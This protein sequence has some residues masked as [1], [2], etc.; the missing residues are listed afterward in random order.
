[1][2]LSAMAEQKG[3]MPSWEVDLKAG[4]PCA[5]Q[6]ESGHQ[7]AQDVTHWQRMACQNTQMACLIVSRHDASSLDVYRNMPPSII[8]R[9]SSFV[10]AGKR[11]HQEE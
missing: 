9:E 5:R 8:Q 7:R 11:K 6:D 4:Q 1:M 3:P 2:N 10:I